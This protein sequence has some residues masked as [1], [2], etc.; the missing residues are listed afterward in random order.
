[1][2]PCTIADMEL[3]SILVSL[4]L[5]TAAYLYVSAV[6]RSY[7]NVLTPMYVLMIPSEYLLDIYHVVKFG[8]SNSAYAYVLSYSCYAAFTV[9]LA[10]AYAKMRMPAIRLPF[11]R[12]SA[13]RGRLPAYLTLAAA[14]ALFLPVL[15]EF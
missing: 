12:L 9:A 14:V 1:M 11:A 5:V 10:W 2:L 6:D 3:A 8:P 4:A 13:G 7:M 15:I